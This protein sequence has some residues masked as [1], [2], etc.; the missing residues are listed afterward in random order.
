MREY[1]IY[2]LSTGIFT[3]RSFSSNNNT[4]DAIF[5]EL[6]TPKNCGVFADVPD[7][8][9]QRVDLDT[10]LL[11]D[12]MPP[13]P[14]ADHEWNGERRRWQFSAAA[15]ERKRALSRIQQLELRALRPQ[16]EITMASALGQ[17]ANDEAVTRLESIEAEIESL[18][19][20]LNGDRG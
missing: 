13:A 2:D 3:G 17:P 12:Y 10:G 19:M 5:V 9:S 7:P 8:L 20:L 1:F 6:N 4:N 11:V 16:R 14:S 15:M 18:R